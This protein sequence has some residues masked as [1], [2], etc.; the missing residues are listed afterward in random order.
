MLDDPSIVDYYRVKYVKKIAGQGTPVGGFFRYNPIG[1]LLFETTDTLQ[2]LLPGKVAVNMLYFRLLGVF[3]GCVVLRGDYTR[4]TKLELDAI[5]SQ[6]KTNPSSETI[7]AALDSPRISFGTKG[8]FNFD[9]GPK[10]TVYLDTVYLDDRI[11]VS[12]S[13]R[14]GTPFVF[15]RLSAE[16]KRDGGIAKRWESYLAQKKVY[17]PLV[18]AYAAGLLTL[19]AAPGLFPGGVAELAEKSV[20]RRALLVLVPAVFIPIALVLPSALL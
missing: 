12:K 13:G 15:E 4:L 3:P 7:K 2:H 17:P 11:R 19:I 1:R 14:T 9:V 10:T 18:G 20:T 16:E 6:Y 8:L 5:K